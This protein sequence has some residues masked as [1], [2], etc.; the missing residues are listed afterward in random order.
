M[1]Q[2]VTNLEIHLHSCLCES[3]GFKIARSSHRRCSIK[4]VFLRILQNWQGITCDGV[5]FLITFLTFFNNVFVKNS[6]PGFFL[7]V[8]WNFLEH[9]FYRILP[10]NCFGIGLIVKKINYVSLIFLNLQLN[11]APPE[12]SVLFWCNEEYLL[13][14]KMSGVNSGTAIICEWNQRE[15]VLTF[16]RI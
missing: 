15:Y 3:R 4:K 16:F 12:W 7:S 9:L 6:D 1:K 10:G 5:S 14:K 2:I 11:H 13:M 8:L